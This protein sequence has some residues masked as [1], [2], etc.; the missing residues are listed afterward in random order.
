MIVKQIE[1]KDTYNIRNEILRPGLPLETCYFEGDADGA[2]IHIGA[3]VDEKLASIASFYLSRNDAFTDVFKF[4]LRGMATLKAYQGQGLSSALLKA[5][6][7]LIKN[8]HVNMLWCNA[9]S[10]AVGFYEK[11]GFHNPPA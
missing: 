8:N 9:R 10:S 11:I 5:A 1:A 2:T 4:Q 7:P 3:F 6:F